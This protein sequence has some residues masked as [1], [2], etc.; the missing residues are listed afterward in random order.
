MRI[1]ATP[2]SDEDGP[3]LADEVL[4]AVGSA[5]P[6]SPLTKRA[7]AAA[8]PQGCTTSVG[9]TARQ[10][11][12]SAC[13]PGPSR[14]GPRW[15]WRRACAGSS[16]IGPGASAARCAPARSGSGATSSSARLASI[17]FTTAR[18]TS[19][20]RLVPTKGGSFAPDSANMPASLM[21]PGRITETPTPFGARSSRSDEREAA[22][23][24]LRRRVDRGAGRGRAARQRGHEEQVPAAAR[25]HRLGQAVGEQHRRAQVDVER[26]VDLLGRE[27]VQPPAARAARRWRRGRRPRPPRRA[28]AP[29]RPPPPGRRR[30]RA[31]RPRRRAA[32]APPRAARSASESPRGRASPR[33]IACP[34]PPVAPVSSTRAPSSFTTSRTVRAAN[35]RKLTRCVNELAFAPRVMRRPPRWR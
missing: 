6:R 1:Q 28:A 34:S 22:Q 9:P 30:S 21:K 31:H 8:H 14:T 2:I 11:T 12:P 26:A 24:E 3:K 32:R 5:T 23:A 7:P 17:A 19:S 10:Q 15:R 20:G 4:A 25:D 27:R 13:R 16:P 29:E 18:A 35:A 33:A